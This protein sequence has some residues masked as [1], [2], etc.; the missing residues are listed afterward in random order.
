MPE[1]RKLVQLTLDEQEWSLLIALLGVG[2][3]FGGSIDPAIQFIALYQLTRQQP[4]QDRVNGLTQ[5]I[6][7][8]GEVAFDFTISHINVPR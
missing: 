5:K 2:S 4:T 6:A 7:K 1:P 3:A 8:L